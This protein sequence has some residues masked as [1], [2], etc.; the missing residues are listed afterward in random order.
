MLK[1]RRFNP[2][3]ITSQHPLPSVLSRSRSPLESQKTIKTDLD[4]FRSF[5]EKKH[6]QQTNVSNAGLA[7]T[8]GKMF[9]ESSQFID[10]NMIET[11]DYNSTKRP[12]KF[13]RK[14]SD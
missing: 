4:Q 11:E 2:N 9:V 14:Q 12:F 1:K 6:S 10:G 13:R 8:K 5:L 7:H 3:F